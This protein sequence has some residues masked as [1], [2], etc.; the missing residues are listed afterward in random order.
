MGM[1]AALLGVKKHAAVGIMEMLWHF[2]ARYSPCGNIGKYSNEA[3]AAALEW[4][5]TDADA[6]ISALV[7]C[8]WLDAMENPDVRLYVHD[9]HVHGQDSS[10]KFLLQKGLTYA[11]GVAPRRKIKNKVQTSTDKYRPRQRKYRQV[12]T[13]LA[14]TVSV[15]VSES[16]SPRVTDTPAI[17]SKI[18][19]CFER[20]TARPEL[21]HMT[22]EQFMTARQKHVAGGVLVEDVADQ[23]EEAAVLMGSID[24]PGVWL[25]RQLERIEKGLGEAEKN[26]SPGS[27]A[28]RGLYVPLAEREEGE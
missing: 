15:S 6:L 24:S 10:D 17:S 7:K 18:R 3:I 9:W 5:I 12:Q 16:V 23:V 13:S 25:H 8:R 19:T 11:N 2:A 28:D 22:F 26:K 14:E 27:V 1:L 21:R 20:L 4:E